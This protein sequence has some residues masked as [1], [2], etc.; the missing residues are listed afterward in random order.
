MMFTDSNQQLTNEVKM[1]YKIEQGNEEINS[2]G[3]VSLIGGILKKA[4]VF[5]AVDDLIMSKVKKGLVPHSG[6]LK[7][8][9][10]LF[11]MGKTDYADV[12]SHRDDVVFKESLE[13]PSVPSEET[14]RQRL[15]DAAQTITDEVL[16]DNVE[17]LKQVKDF[18]EVKT[19][20]STYTP[21]DMDVT[22]LDNGGTQKENVGRTY[23]GCDGYAPMMAY[24]GTFG[25][26]LNCELRPG[27]QHSQNGM[28]A[29]LP[30]TIAMV[31]KLGVDNALYILDSAHDAAETIDIFQSADCKFL[32]KRNLRRESP[33]QWLDLAAGI[34]KPVEPRPGK[35]VYIGGTPHQ[36]PKNCK[37]ENPLFTVFEVIERTTDHLGEELLIPSVEVNLWW[38]NTYEDGETCVRLYHDHGTSEQFHSE[39]KTDVG[40]ERLASG[41]FKTN[42]LL[43]Q[44]GMIAFNVLRLMGQAA[45][46]FKEALPFKLNV[47]RRRLR[48]VMRDLVYLACKRVAHANRVILKFGRHCPWFECFRLLHVMFC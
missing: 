26:M 27:V 38:T 7:T 28:D 31:E 9:V 41:K 32:V 22:P 3:G 36:R 30:R 11:C 43:T 2:T 6:I 18:G 25:H 37:S 14:L 29:F 34:V 15:D 39:Y 45:L 40:I 42:A 10:G 48:S 5:K 1:S 16:D 21:V 19:P 46:G 12:E 24:I 20:H 33:E 13:L 44:L 35:K 4:N 8:M 23:K 17:L 47:E